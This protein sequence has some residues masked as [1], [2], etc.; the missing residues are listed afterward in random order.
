MHEIGLISL[1]DP[2]VSHVYV[3]G[4]TNGGLG[5]EKTLVECRVERGGAGN[6]WRLVT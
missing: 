1:T 2:A 3:A 6:A 5:I 4:S